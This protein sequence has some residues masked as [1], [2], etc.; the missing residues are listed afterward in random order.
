MEKQLFLVACPYAIEAGVPG[1]SSVVKWVADFLW[2]DSVNS[3]RCSLI[4]VW[5]PGLVKDSST[6]FLKGEWKAMHL[7][8][9][10]YNWTA[11]AAPCWWR[12]ATL[13]GFSAVIC[14]RIM[15]HLFHLWLG[16]RLFSSWREAKV[17]SFYTNFFPLDFQAS[18]AEGVSQK[19]RKCPD[20]CSSDRTI[21]QPRVYCL[22]G[23]IDLFGTYSIF[24]DR[25][26]FCCMV[27]GF[28]RIFFFYKKII[29]NFTHY[30]LITF[31]PFLQLIP[32]TN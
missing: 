31:F 26:I 21:L 1:S 29:E 20:F 15:W 23:I 7:L 28:T 13:R 32:V 27:L 3:I 17:L 16:T 8:E 4:K 6:S 25:Y 24:I 14:P 2:D 11:I 9:F 30:I 12:W 18:F 5:P 10:K 22:T 19:S